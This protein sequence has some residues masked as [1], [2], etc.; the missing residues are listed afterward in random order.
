MYSDEEEVSVTEGTELSKFQR[1]GSYG[2]N[3]VEG[4][5]APWADLWP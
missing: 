4:P 2:S 1:T 5:R 3:N